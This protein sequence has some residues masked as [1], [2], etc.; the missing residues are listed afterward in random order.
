[1]KNINMSAADLLDL[2]TAT[3]ATHSRLVTELVKAGKYNWQAFGGGDGTGA[4]IS[5]TSCQSFMQQYCLSS[6]Q[7]LPL[8]MGS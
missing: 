7:Q 6:Y 8:M 5:E 1:M 2:R 3:T 4:S